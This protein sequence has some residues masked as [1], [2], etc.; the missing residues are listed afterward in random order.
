V[1]TSAT[2]K[3][4]LEMTDDDID[5][6]IDTNIYRDSSPWIGR[7]TRYT[8]SST[9][10]PYWKVWYDGPMDDEGS[11][12]STTRVTRQQLLNGFV[13]AAEAQFNKKHFGLCCIDDMLQDKSLA[14]GCAQDSD[15]VM[16]FA[17]LGDEAPIYG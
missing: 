10:R 6:M 12:A 15:L 14:I 3:L 17:I 2:L 5:M 1:T 8:D 13:A 9:D 7:I 11:F 16:Q 4:P